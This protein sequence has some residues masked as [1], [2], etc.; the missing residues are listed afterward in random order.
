M[1]QKNDSRGRSDVPLLQSAFEDFDIHEQLRTL[2][3]SCVPL[4]FSL[5]RTAQ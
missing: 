2:S 1:K 4:S 5:I 3:E